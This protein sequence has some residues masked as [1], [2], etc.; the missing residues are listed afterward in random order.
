MGALSFANPAYLWGALA[1]ALPLAIHLFSRRRP[2]PLPFGAIELVLRSQKQKRRNLRLRQLLLLALRCLLIAALALALAR[3]SLVPRTE[4]AQAA[5]GPHA[6]ALVLDASLS[7]RYRMGG[8]TLFEKSRAEA[9]AALE[10]L[11]P[12]EPA[13][14]GL[15]AGPAGF[16]EGG[17]AAPSFDRAAVRRILTTAQP[18]EVASD[19]T[20]CLDAAA[21]TLGESMVSGKRIFAFT[22]M[23]AHAF[24]L[25]APPPL[26]PA[27]PSA[28]G[29]AAPIRPEIV[30]VD[31]AEGAEL[32]NVAILSVSAA[33]APRLGP[34]G[35]EV[36]ATIG[37]F[38]AHPLANVEVELRV[39]GHALAKGFVDLPAH[40]TGKKLLGAVLPA[41]LAAGEVVLAHADGPGL[42]EDDARA[43]AI[44]VP[45]DLK[46]LIID[47][48]PASLRERDEAW[49]VEAALNPAR[50]AGRITA[51]TLDQDAAE[52]HPLDGVD[53]VLLL[54]PQVPSKP[55][56]ERLR[57]F[58]QK[59][60]GLFI[61]LGDHTDPDALN[62]SLASLLPRPLHLLKTARDPDASDGQGGLPP[63]ARF[64]SI[65]W[66]HP[67][68]RVFGPTE[69][70]ALESVH[71]NRYALLAAD[72]KQS[73]RILASFDDG[74]PALIE[75][76]LGA[77]RVLLFTSSASA[78]WNDWP[79]HPSFL[80]V[81]QQA[82]SH[83]AGALEER[84]STA[85]QVG[86]QRV[87]S[88]ARGS[89][90]VQVLGPDNRP[91][92]L[93]RELSTNS[94]KE[95][96]NGFAT[97]SK[98]APGKVGSDSGAETQGQ[99]DAFVVAVALPG[100][101]R[102]Q[103]APMGAST[104]S[105]GEARD[106]PSLAFAAGLDAKE[107]DLRRVDEA[108]LKALL[109]GASSAQVASS[110]LSA[111]GNGGTALWPA[112][113]LLCVLALLGEGAL[114]RR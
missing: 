33:A 102:V 22:D 91:L 57:A 79:L 40:E 76:Q 43:F 113:L 36:A 3:P 19:M 29:Q 5:S 97:S 47:G 65:D 15:C 73:V 103:T 53:V 55:L 68:F 50:T 72:G 21:H 75:S 13:T 98:T 77:G 1:V 46:A 74:A 99:R 114:T 62:E 44:Q 12:E 86:D 31:A 4:S 58:V 14:A 11:T 87:I 37:N 111:Q 16:G 106:D 64:A 52:N 7:M 59:G 23:S 10:R 84:V 38:S 96:A 60:G 28:S 20:A 80:P 81:V 63:P 26:T 48:A 89:R 69:R 108:E 104:N 56:S 66:Q 92:A 6:T 30:L 18:S 35:Y 45:R 39:D 32:P 71:V 105:A 109:G 54:N 9:L 42:D 107:S 67:I 83:L 17:L 93:S 51:Q 78:S 27:P 82:V 101:Y 24:R 112:L 41:G 25:D 88:A 8:K 100:V 70:E 110:S 61:A 90:I 94:A 34:R 85:S 2:R 49:F 95:A